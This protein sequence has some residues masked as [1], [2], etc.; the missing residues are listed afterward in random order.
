MLKTKVMPSILAADIGNLKVE[1]QRAEAAGSDGLHLDIMD[2]TFVNN[3]SLGFNVI[4]E[5][6]QW[7]NIHLSVHLMI[8][9]PDQYVERCAEFGADTILIHQE[10]PCD[11]PATVR[12]MR[13]LGVRAG[14]TL[15]PDT[16]AETLA[17]YLE[18]IDEV[19]VMSVWPG[20]GGQSFIE[21]VLLKVSQLREMKPELDIS[22]DGGI[23]QDTAEKAAR[24]GANIFQVGTFMFKADSMADQISEMR[25]RTGAALASR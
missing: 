6:K 18:E 8:V 2:G 7:V 24:A 11:V 25:V 5:A 14:V 13:E 21:D 12:K 23:N 20:F 15:N 3:I 17:D 22:I 9:R 4:R 19:L 10:A 1:C 16:P